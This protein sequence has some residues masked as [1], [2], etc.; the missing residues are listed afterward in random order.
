MQSL[1]NTFTIRFLSPLLQ[2]RVAEFGCNSSITNTLTEEGQGLRSCQY[3]LEAQAS[4]S[5]CTRKTHSPHSLKRRVCIYVT[6][7]LS[8]WS[9]LVLAI[10]LLVFW[11]AHVSSV[12]GQDVKAMPWVDKDSGELTPMG[13]DYRGPA[14]TRDRS[15][16]PKKVIKPKAAKA[17]WNPNWNFRGGGTSLGAAGPILVYGGGSIAVLLLV[18][19]MVW[20]FM[21]SRIDMGGSDDFSSRPDRTLEESIRHL[22]FEMD[23]KKGDFQQQAQTAYE[24]GDFRTALVFLFSH[25]L[26]TLDQAKLVRLK[27]GKTNRQYLR[28]LSPSRPLVKY[29]GD[30][31]VPFEQTFFGDY[32]ITKEV[33]EDCWQGLERF[34]NSVDEARSSTR[35]SSTAPVGVVL[36]NTVEGAGTNA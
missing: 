26:V 9:F 23:V 28:E 3:R 6:A 14:A 30:V 17:P 25:V 15:L 32:P 31:M 8:R 4:E 7:K 36:P 33:F 24:A 16:I 22:P 10:P 11:L 35:R 21:N 18:A 29:Y 2:S 5:S 1:L 20:V 12:V 34:Q 27:K 13:I 19:L